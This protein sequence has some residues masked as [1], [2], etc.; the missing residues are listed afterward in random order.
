M[1]LDELLVDPPALPIVLSD[2][3]PELIDPFEEL[4]E[5]PML[6]LDELPALPV[7]PLPVA[8]LVDEPPP[9]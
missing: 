1:S 8:P 4:P 6:P 7:S 5:L 3:L 2:E 9:D